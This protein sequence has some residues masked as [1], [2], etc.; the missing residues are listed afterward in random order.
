M[1]KTKTVKPQPKQNSYSLN[2]KTSSNQTIDK[3]GFIQIG[4]L[5]KTSFA[6]TKRK[7]KLYD[8]YL[9]KD[10]NDQFKLFYRRSQAEIDDLE[11]QAAN[12]QLDTKEKIK[13]SRKLCKLKE[14]REYNPSSL[15][16]GNL[17]M[18][19]G[20]QNDKFL[21]HPRH[22]LRDDQERKLRFSNTNLKFSSQEVDIKKIISQRKH[23]GW[24]IFGGYGGNIKKQFSLEVFDPKNQA[25]SHL[26][27][28]PK[29]KGFLNSATKIKIT[30]SEKSHHAK[31]NNLISQPRGTNFF[32]AI[33]DSFRG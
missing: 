27:L 24:K 29:T 18:I 12:Q 31:P 21:A 13:I 7:E 19:L 20:N 6:L 26:T 3:D 9:Q 16:S 32:S 28:T 17:T 33:R 1:I 10:Q 4:N 25:I 23:N 2:L 15:K 5:Y 11:K 14:Y 30:E 22:Y 8:F